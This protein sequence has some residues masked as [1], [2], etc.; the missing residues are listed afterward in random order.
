MK[1]SIFRLIFL[2]LIA[3][4]LSHAADAT[5]NPPAKPRV[6]LI[7]APVRQESRVYRNSPEGELSL[8]FFWPQEGKS[9]D[10]R[11]AIIFFHGSTASASQFFPQ[12]EYFASRGI[13]CASA[14]YPETGKD[15]RRLAREELIGNAKTAVRWLRSHAPELGV[16]PAKLIAAGGSLGGFLALQTTVVPGIDAADHDPA[17]SC[18]PNALVLFNPVVQVA[19]R[20]GAPPAIIFFG[21]ADPLNQPALEFMARSRALG[22]RCD[23]FTAADQPHSFFNRQPW[24]SAT[25]IE[26]DKFLAS[27]GYLDGAPTLKPADVTAVMVQV[28]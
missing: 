6:K 27:L 26:A 9:S 13:V 24:A 16:D 14:D 1:R 7:E 10:R 25:V 11:P 28:K 3:T 2:H 12:A 19:A 20:K 23:Y 18:E 5:A 21:T 17:I 8:H 4:V 15:G 22:N